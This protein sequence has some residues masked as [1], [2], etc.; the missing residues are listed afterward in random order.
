M[1]PQIARRLDRPEWNPVWATCAQE[2]T[3]RFAATT[4]GASCCRAVLSCHSARLRVSDGPAQERPLPNAVQISSGGAPPLARRQGAVGSG[5][6]VSR[7]M[8]RWAG[9]Q[10]AVG[11]GQ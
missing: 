9:R 6:W 1:A 3:R 5:Q 4:G 7:Q 2:A 8:G 11:S 10:L